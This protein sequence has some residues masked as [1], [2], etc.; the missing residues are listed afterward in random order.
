MTSDT[1]SLFEFMLRLRT[2]PLSVLQPLF[3]HL[4]LGSEEPRNLSR[5]NR[6]T[7]DEFTG[8]MVVFGF[9]DP[10]K[11]VIAV[12]FH[13]SVDVT[14]APPWADDYMTIERMYGMSPVVLALAGEQAAEDILAVQNGAKS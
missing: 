9:G 14:V 11:H 5:E 2:S 4:D 13:G 7:P 3:P 12:A 10:L 1:L 6:G 8:F